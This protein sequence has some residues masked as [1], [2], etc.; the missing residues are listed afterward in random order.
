MIERRGQ[1]IELPTTGH[2]ALA[3]GERSDDVLVRD[4]VRIDPSDHHALSMPQLP[5]L[6]RT[7]RR[8]RSGSSRSRLQAW[9]RERAT[10]A[11]MKLLS[12]RGS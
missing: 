3:V 7:M 5:V 9:R 2:D 11:S 12:L 6:H 1:R 8:E 4:I 10:I